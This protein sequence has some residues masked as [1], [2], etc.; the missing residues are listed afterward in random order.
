V[1]S[2]FHQNLDKE[3]FIETKTLVLKK[4]PKVVQ[5]FAAENF[6]MKTLSAAL[7]IISF[8][9]LILVAYLIKRGPQVIA[10]DATGEVAKIELKVTDAQIAR[11]VEEYISYR[12]RWN[13][14]NINSQLKL[15]E[16]FIEDSLVPS[17]QKSMVDVQRFVKDKKVTQRVYPSASIKVD[18]REK[19][20][21][22]VADRIT[23]FD[24]LSAATK[25]KVVLDFATGKRTAVNPWGIY[26]RKETEGDLR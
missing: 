24:S 21:V 16:A 15:S 11:A 23:E 8:L 26:I 2:T 19:K 3:V 18:L 1:L 22:V 14:E 25:L 10:I 6:N 12:Y 9:L 17:F 20:V 7:I 13:P 5:D 4:Y